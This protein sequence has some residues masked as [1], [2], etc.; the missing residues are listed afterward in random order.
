VAHKPTIL[1]VDNELS[2][3]HYLERSVARMGY[4]V[5]A[6]SDPWAALAAFES[7]PT[8][9]DLLITDLSMPGIPGTELLGRARAR[10]SDLPAILMTGYADDR[11][12]ETDSASDALLLLNPF[13]LADLKAVLVRALP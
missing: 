13:T 2:L 11:V 8:K 6:Y 5:D 4:G 10:R 1:M 12:G 9:F 3:L 7:E